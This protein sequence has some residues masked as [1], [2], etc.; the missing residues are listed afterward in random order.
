MDTAAEMD[1]GCICSCL[2]ALNKRLLRHLDY[3]WVAKASGERKSSWKER[4][5]HAESRSSAVLLLDANAMPFSLSSVASSQPWLS[6][7]CSCLLLCLGVGMSSDGGMSLPDC[8]ANELPEGCRFTI[9]HLSSPPTQCPAIFAAPPGQSP[10]ETYC[11]SQFLSVSIKHRDQHLQVFAIE[12]LIYTTK[13]LTTLFVSKA[14]STGYLY[15]LD[16]PKGT[17]SPL[18]IICTT[19]LSFLIEERMRPDRRL[20]LSLFAR[21]QDQYLFPGSIEN[22]HKHVLDDRGLIKWWCKVADPLLEGSQKQEKEEVLYLSSH[23]LRAGFLRVPGCDKYETRGFFP[24]GQAGEEHCWTIA[25]PLQELAPSASLPERCLV[26]RFP[27]DPKARFL[28][29]LDDEL[30]EEETQESQVQRSDNTE[31]AQTLPGLTG[32]SLTSQPLIGQPYTMTTA[33]EEGQVQTGKMPSSQR[34][35]AGRWRSIRSLDQFWDMMSFRQECSAGRLVGFLWAVFTPLELQNTNVDVQMAG[36]GISSTSLPTPMDSQHQ[37]TDRLPPG[38]PLRSSP[39]REAPNTPRSTAQ[40]SQVPPTP[41]RVKVQEIQQLQEQPARTAYYLWPPSSRGEI[42]LRAKDYKMVG[43]LL[44]RLDYAD[45]EIAMD[46]TKKLID[47]VVKRADTQSWGRRVVGIKKTAASVPAPAANCSAPA[48]MLNAGLV[49]KKKRPAAD[50]ADEGGRDNPAINALS[51][52]LFRK[53][54]NTNDNA[55]ELAKAG[56]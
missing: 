32:Q 36:R 33:T 41:S 29:D 56:T 30:P 43:D 31:A 38:S 11:E 9:H 15:L 23:P 53:K 16:L 10:E 46:S 26:P 20:V 7:P 14:D 40:P 48:T 17:P 54:V 35:N 24:K 6:G 8:F 45:E 27:D 42:V 2:L 5:I 52:D 37:E 3:L 21:A 49:R 25:D 4:A 1:I 55:D 44:L 12:V 47:D 39:P 19:F 13:L 51:A 34:S 50:G 22:S 28:I 18:R